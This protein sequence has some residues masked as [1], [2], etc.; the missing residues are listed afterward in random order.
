M[1]TRWLAFGLLAPIAGARSLPL[2][3]GARTSARSAAAATRFRVSFPASAHSA[4]ITGR[5]I[6]V[7]SRTEQPEPRMLVS[8][9]GPAVFG[10]DL[11]QVKPGH[12]VV[13]DNRAASYPTSLD[14]L[15]AGDYYVQ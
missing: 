8:P 7:V 3:R 13:V 10:I 11:D 2:A 1:R 4:P 12:Q 14:S 5:L 9:S 6:V 15:P